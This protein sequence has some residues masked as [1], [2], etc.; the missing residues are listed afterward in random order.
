MKAEE[1]EEMR[2]GKVWEGKGGDVKGNERRGDIGSK[3]KLEERY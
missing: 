3:G 1:A 2:R